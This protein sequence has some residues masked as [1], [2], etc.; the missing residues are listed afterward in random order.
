MPQPKGCIPWNRNKKLSETHIENLSKSHK[1]QHSSPD[2]EIKKGQ[3]LSPKT[4][5]KKGFKALSREK[6]YAWKGGKSKTRK[7]YILIKNRKHPFC[8][9][10]G[11]VLEH[12]LVMEKYLERYLTKQEFVHHKNGIKN[13]NRIENL[14][15]Y[16]LGKNWHPETCPKCGFKFSV[17]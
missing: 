4:E 9:K 2:T 16:V 8:D 5:F 7:G 1:G 15:L 3:R 12:R 13:D 11:Y 14:H 17:K 6:H 10:Q